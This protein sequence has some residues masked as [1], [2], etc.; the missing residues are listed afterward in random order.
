MKKNTISFIAVASAI[1]MMGNTSH[2]LTNIAYHKVVEGDTLSDITY[3][4]Y[5]T[6][7]YVDMLADYNNI[8]DKNVI[9]VG[10]Y[11]SLPMEFTNTDNIVNEIL[12]NYTIQ[13][14][15]T[16]SSICMEYY[17]N[18][19]IDTIW[20]VATYNNLSNPN[21]IYAG[22]NLFIPTK[23]TLDNIYSLDYSAVQYEYFGDVKNELDNPKIIIYPDY[24][25][26]NEEIPNED[27]NCKLIIK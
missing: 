7:K 26:I 5:G 25:Y 10:Q 6:T 1:M 24:M 13:E 14:G 3:K 2:A 23:E 16:L 20:K 15:D 17:K 9:N 18:N 21:I 12:E 4:F 19:N 11:I 27:N 22:N 8:K